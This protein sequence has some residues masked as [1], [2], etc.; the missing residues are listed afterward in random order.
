MANQ[1]RLEKI[2]YWKGMGLDRIAELHWTVWKQNNDLRK[3]RQRSRYEAHK[4]RM[5]DFMKVR[6]AETLLREN[7]VL[8]DVL[9]QN[10]VRPKKLIVKYTVSDCDNCEFWNSMEK[11]CE[12]YDRYMDDCPEREITQT[13][14]FYTFCIDDGVLSGIEADFTNGEYNTL[15]IID[16][17]TGKILFKQEA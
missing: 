11:C 1:E 7:E 15:E 8:K 6:A 14:G 5:E 9:Q 3:E 2:A 16:D 12:N 4:E 17:K 10:G 13:I